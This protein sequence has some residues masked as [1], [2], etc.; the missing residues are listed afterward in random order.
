MHYIYIYISLCSSF[1]VISRTLLLSTRRGGPT[2]TPPGDVSDN[3]P[4]HAAAAPHDG[5]SGAI[6]ALLRHADRHGDASR[7][8]GRHR[9]PDDLLSQGRAPNG[10][11]LLGQITGWSF[12]L[13]NKIRVSQ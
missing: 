2:R 6:A 11:G 3:Y 5:A 7:R 4:G 9:Q 12:G 10:G 1:S 13:R 8:D